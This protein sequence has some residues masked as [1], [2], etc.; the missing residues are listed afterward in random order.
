MGNP[1][2][3]RD[4]DGATAGEHVTPV[5][6]TDAAIWPDLVVP[7]EIIRDPVHGDIE[8]SAVEL[9]V[10]DLPIF[11]R[12]RGIRQLGPTHLVYPGA[13][14]T[15]FDHS[16]GTL[17]VASLI[18]KV[19]QERA[20]W[21]PDAC[22]LS[23]R[24]E[25]LVR[26]KALLHDVA[27]VP[28]GHTL[29]DEGN[30]FD[31]KSQW[32]CDDRL[33]LLHDAGSLARRIRASLVA[34]GTSQDAATAFWNDLKQLVPAENA[35]DYEN[36]PAL[37]DIVAGP[38]CADNVDY[39]QRDAF[40]AGLP[41]RMGDRFMRYLAIL[42]VREVSAPEKTE[43]MMLKE[44]DPAKMECRFLDGPAFTRH[45]P[46]FELAEN[47][48]GKP[49]LILCPYK[50]DRHGKIV[51]SRSAITEVI[52]FHRR[53]YSLTEKVYYH[54]TKRIASAM[55]CEAYNYDLQSRARKHPEDLVNWQE[56]SLHAALASSES[57]DARFL[58]QC[59][60]DRDLYDVGLEISRQRHRDAKESSR[61]NN[62]CRDPQKRLKLEEELR[63]FLGFEHPVI[64]HYPEPVVN[65]RRFNPIVR[66][67]GQL[68]IGGL[69]A[70]VS[71]DRRK[72][73]Q[74][75]G[76]HHA[77]FWRAAVC[78]YSDDFHEGENMA[79][80]R[81]DIAIFLGEDERP[82][83]YWEPDLRTA[84]VQIRQKGYDLQDHQVDQILAEIPP[85]S[86]RGKDFSTRL[87]RLVQIFEARLGE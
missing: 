85:R 4:F 65:P 79:D 76:A 13:L 77:Y 20:S 37:I 62:D 66:Y 34:K 29:E 87:A 46:F 21:D 51:A 31:G 43:S 44:C 53:R 64:I 41:E 2:T 80:V 3:L 48:E 82:E 45:G 33:E 55:L 69:L 38:L 36:N 60:Q 28:Y 84:I 10:I 14:H 5:A 63:D 40:F 57:D 78:V 74:V 61:L 9:D 16:L 49:R 39:L 42:K 81:R 6:D 35:S 73:T 56:N 67:P 50:R 32:E 59:I 17:H 27:H 52:D 47:G 18:I 25:C 26:L 23:P 15:R 71:A 75:I 11:Q 70:G 72:E 22:N 1:S 8:L 86:N 24:D 68:D 12:L 58:I 30:L 7:A 54:R 19:I 83:G